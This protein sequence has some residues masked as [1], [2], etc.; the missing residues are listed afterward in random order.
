LKT[1]VSRCLLRLAYQS[2]LG[3]PDFGP[4]FAARDRHAGAGAG[5]A[6]TER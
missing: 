1:D 2:L 4:Q 6:V 5:G 3:L